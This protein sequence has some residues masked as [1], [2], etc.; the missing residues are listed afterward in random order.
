MISLLSSFKKTVKDRIRVGRGSSSGKGGTSGKGH[1]GQLAR[2]GKNSMKHFEGGQ[3]PIFRRL[4]KRGFKFT[5]KKFE[6]VAIP[7]DVLISKISL[8]Q[9][10]SFDVKSIYKTNSKNLK[11][12]IIGCSNL[13]NILTEKISV[14]EIMHVDYISNS[15]KIFLEK[16]GISIKL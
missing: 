4:P 3:T 10:E 14:K 13:K 8:I 15:A 7:I 6:S 9:S 12:K 11:I 1:K 16:S 2:S 5:G